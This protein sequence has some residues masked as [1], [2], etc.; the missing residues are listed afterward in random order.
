MIKRK[1]I[2]KVLIYIRIL[3]DTLL[4][5]T[6]R[7]YILQVI[8]LIVAVFIEVSNEA[9]IE[10]TWRDYESTKVFEIFEGRT[11]RVV[12]LYVESLTDN[13]LINEQF[14]MY[15]EVFQ[16]RIFYEQFSLVYYMR[17][18]LPPFLIWIWVDVVGFYISQPFMQ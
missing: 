12:T 15:M 2:Y 1:E 3:E 17:V 9:F 10:N 8:L 14:K 6:G 16:I 4:G 13:I 18:I 11:H 5:N 7:G